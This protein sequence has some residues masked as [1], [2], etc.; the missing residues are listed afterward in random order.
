MTEGRTL[1]LTPPAKD[2][3]GFL[4]RQRRMMDID[5]RIKGGDPTAMDEM[6]DVLLPFVTEPSDRT[7]AADALWELSEAQFRE[8]MTAF[9]G[10]TSSTGTNADSSG[11]TSPG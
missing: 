10:R 2:A 3:P 11:G 6:V 1:K 7:A 9:L 4:R 8:V 5:R